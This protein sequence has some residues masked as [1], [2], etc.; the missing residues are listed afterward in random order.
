MSVSGS[1]GGIL[2]GAAAEQGSSHTSVTK[3]MPP[4]A[5]LHTTPEAFDQVRFPLPRYIYACVKVTKPK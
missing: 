1:I 2:I 4:E 3:K 5:C